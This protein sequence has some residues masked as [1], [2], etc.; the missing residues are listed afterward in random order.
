MILIYGSGQFSDIIYQETSISIS[1]YLYYNLD[2]V[3]ERPLEFLSPLKD[4]EV[5]EDDNIFLVCEVSRRDVTGCWMKAGKEIQKSNHFNFHVEGTKHTLE[6][7]KA[8]LDDQADYEFRIMDKSTK[9][10]VK[11]KGMDIKMFILLM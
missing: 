5:I 11:V 1:H 6:V 9:A 3:T 2:Y 7:N 10:Y 8:K 4:Q